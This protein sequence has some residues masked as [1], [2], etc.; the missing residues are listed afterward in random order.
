MNPPDLALTDACLQVGSRLLCRRWQ[1]GWNPTGLWSLAGG[2]TW[3]QI[4]L[5]VGGAF[6]DIRALNV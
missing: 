1:L 3:W 2:R 6:T 5:K 4:S